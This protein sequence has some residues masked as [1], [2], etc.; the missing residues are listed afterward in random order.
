[1]SHAIDQIQSQDV[2]LLDGAMTQEL[3]R[4]GARSA[5]ELSAT[6]LQRNPELVQDIHEAYL[7]AGADIITTNTYG[8]ARE[9]LRSA[10]LGDHFES[11]NR[12]AG[13]LAVAARDRVRPDALIAGSLPPLRGSYRPDQVGTFNEMVSQYGE[14]ARTLAPYV[15]LFICETMS[16]AQE[17]RA[18]AT[19]AAATEKPVF[20]AWTVRGA[21]ARQNHSVL[22]RSGETLTAALDALDDVPV[23][24]YLVNCSLPKHITTAIPAL[25]EQTD[26]LIGGY[27]NGFESIPDD[28]TEGSDPPPDQRSDLGPAAYAT[29]VRDW[30]EDGADIVGGCCEIGPAHIKHLRDVIGAH[31]TAP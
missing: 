21:P 1:M 17:A 15:D 4:R 29:Y 24:G 3:Y 22:L 6:V 14:H 5:D 8:T 16:T 13:R 12:T 11:F 30:I 20:V 7:R 31:P 25:R 26:R 23:A 28:W 10:E 2:T 18:A 27:A 19:G 9:R